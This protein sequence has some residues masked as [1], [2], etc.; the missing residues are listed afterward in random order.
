MKT[1]YWIALL[2]AVLVICL[3]LSVVLLLPGEAAEFAEIYSRGKLLRTVDLRIE[4]EFTVDTPSGGHNVVAVRDGKIAVTEANCPDHYCM[5]RGFCNSGSHIVCLPNQLVIQ[6]G[7][8]E[9]TIDAV[10]G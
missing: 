5:E 8:G 4:Q 6:F 3:G 9:E 7:G 2:A 10:V 1:G